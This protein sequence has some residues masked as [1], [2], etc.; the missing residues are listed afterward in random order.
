MTVSM[1]FCKSIFLSKRKSYILY[2]GKDERSNCSHQKGTS[3]NYKKEEMNRPPFDKRECKM[4]I[5]NKGGTKQ[6]PCL[7]MNVE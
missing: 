1:C 6:E 4:K 7:A 2:V 3:I 5:Q